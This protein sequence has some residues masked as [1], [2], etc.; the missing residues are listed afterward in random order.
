[1]QQGYKNFYLYSC[2]SPLSGESFTLFLPEVNTDMMNIFFEELVKEYPDK[3]III[4]MDQAGWHKTKDLKHPDTVTPLYL[5]S[6]S[7]ELNPIEKLWQWL[8]KEV[9]HNAVFHK[10]EDMMDALEKEIRRLTS[11]K[12]AQ[13]CHCSYL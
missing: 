6:Y 4:V 13:L 2:V 10:F 9:T 12:L 5:P 1:V 8:R 7:P 3:E 11:E